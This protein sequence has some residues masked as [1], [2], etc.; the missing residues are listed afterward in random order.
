MKKAIVIGA[1]IAGCSTA[2]ALAKRGISVTLIE[3]H[4]MIAQEASGNPVAMLHPK[5]NTGASTLST[6]AANGFAFTLALLKQLQTE[7][8]IFDLC[9]Q[10]QLAFNVHEQEKQSALLNALGSNGNVQL[11]TISEASEK[12]N[13]ALRVGGLYLPDAGWVKPKMFCASLLQSNLVT[14]VVSTK[15][16]N[17]EKTDNQWQVAVEEV[18]VLEADIVVICNANDIHRFDWCKHIPVTPV[19]GQVNFFAENHFSHQ[20][21]SVICSDHYL[22]PSVDGL[23]SIGSSY[24]PNDASLQLSKADTQANLRALN[25]ISPTLFNSINL[26]EVSGRVAWRSTT[27]DYMPLAGQLINDQLLRQLP[28]RYDAS[29]NDLPWLKGLYV[30]AGHGSKGMITAPLCGELIANQINNEPLVVNNAIASKLNPSRFLLRA[31]GL[32]KIA[33]NLY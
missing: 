30:N 5:L 16:I 24:A 15:A 29:P 2:Y 25:K 19:R 31:L 6:I 26:S 10:I 23:H 17:I 22:S 9:G 8:D 33:Q 11:L 3:R 12:A 28:P 32:K 20:I 13:I 7:N 21:K 14:S 18:H 4:E 27:Q 1:G